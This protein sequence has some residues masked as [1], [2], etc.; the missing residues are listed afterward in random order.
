MYQQKTVGKKFAK[1][2][3]FPAC[4]IGAESSAVPDFPNK[5][6]LINAV[7]KNLKHKKRILAAKYYSFVKTDRFD[8]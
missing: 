3:M 1:R 5:M 2:I 4:G 6:D 7:G 8:F